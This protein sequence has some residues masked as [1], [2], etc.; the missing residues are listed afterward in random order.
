MSVTVA[1]LLKL[2]SLRHAKVLGGHRGLEKIVSSI[3][4]LESTDPGVL[5]ND[6]FPQGG[7]YGSEIVITGFMNI[8]DDIDRQ[9]ANIRRL[10]EGGEVGLILFYVGVYLPQVDQR[11]IDLADTLDFVLICMPERIK[12]LRYSEVITDVTEHIYRDR[13]RGVSIVSDILARVSSLPKHH[14]TVNTVLK[15]LSDHLSASVILCSS[16]FHILNLIAWPRGLEDIVKDGIESLRDYPA[17]EDSTICPFLPDCH[18]SRLTVNADPQQMELFLLKEGEPLGHTLLEQAL[19]VVRLGM[20]IWGQKHGIIAIHELV[21]AILRDEPIKMRRLAEIFHIDVAS[22][23]EMWILYG[24]GEHSAEWLRGQTEELRDILAGCAKTVVADCYDGRLLLFLSKPDSLRE[25]EKRVELLLSAALVR[26]G[27]MTLTRFGDLQDTGEVRQAY[28]CHQTCLPDAKKLFPRQQSFCQGEMEYAQTCRSL[29]DQ[30]E[31]TVSRCLS[32][33][34]DL[35][36]DKEN[37]PLLETLGVYLLDG[38]GSVTKTAQLLYLHKNTVKYRIQRISDVL[39][40][41]PNKL[42]EAIHLYQAIAIRRL[43]EGS[44]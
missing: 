10:A 30:G 40:Y 23:H 16:D 6:L 12:T 24:E 13:I 44:D 19:E 5:V 8:V 7:F 33:L 21:R 15:M 3:S 4:V 1:E 17:S 22:I 31:Q 29:I 42:P 25:T 39:G 36:K 27:T 26:D 43:L 28:L 11:L 20:N 35:Q 38:E 9:C 32:V 37:Q 34:R 14:R 2:P 18:L 41:R